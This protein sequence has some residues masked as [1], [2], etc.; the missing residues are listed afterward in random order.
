MGAGAGE[1]FDSVSD[2]LDVVVVFEQA[3]D[4]ALHVGVVLGQQD[5]GADACG[6][7]AR[8]RRRLRL[9]PRG[10][11]DPVRRFLHEGGGVC[12]REPEFALDADTLGGQVGR[13]GR[14]AD[15][16][17]AALP[18]GARDGDRA[19]V[20]PHELAH[21]READAGALEGAPARA[22]H[23]MKPLEEP[24]QLLL[25]DARACVADRELHAIVRP[26]QRDL[27]RP[28]ERE[29]EGVRDQVEDDLLPH[30]AVDVDR[31]GERRAIDDVREPRALDDRAERRR[32][33]SGEGR[34]IGRLVG[35]LQARRLDPG[36]IEQCI[37]ELEQAP[38]IAPNDLDFVSLLVGQRAVRAVQEL[39]DRAEHERERRAEL[40]A[41]V[42]EEAGLE[43]VQSA[44]FFVRDE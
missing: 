13:A 27:D 11:L 30:L 19:F 26:A 28:F 33:L 21:E 34:K 6:R 37:D 15:R 5:V 22:L 7:G 40:V 4:V 20:K 17:C 44:E 29:F 32:E 1:R 14:K 39:L 10:R 2:H 23:A 3:A 25:G 24:R 31:L 38:R 9:D 16:E 36:E 12:C 35:H 43:L 42:G 8:G 18:D 41:H